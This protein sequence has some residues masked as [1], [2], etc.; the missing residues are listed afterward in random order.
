MIRSFEIQNYRGFDHLLLGDLSRVN[1]ITGRNNTGK[2]SILEALFLHAGYHNPGLATR[3]NAFRGLE[4]ARPE[5]TEVWGWLFHSKNVAQAIRLTSLD[6]DASTRELVV[7]LAGANE[8]SDSDAAT[9]DAQTG[10]R[11]VELMLAYS[12]STGESSHASARLT[13]GGIRLQLGRP[14]PAGGG[15]FVS[16]GLFA[17]GEDA[18]RLS[19]LQEV[20]REDEVRDA[21]RIV[22]PRLRRI[23]VSVVGGTA[24]V[25]GD[26][27]MGRLLPV[28][29]MGEGCARLLSI[30]L[31]V[32]AMPGGIVLIDEIENGFHHSILQDVWQAIGNAAERVNA[33]VFATTHSYECIRGAHRAFS[34]WLNYEFR[35]HR[36]DMTRAGVK[37]VTYDRETIES[38]LNAEMEV[39]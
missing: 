5:P 30:L 17:H 13:E 4:S 11:P 7:S 15:V 31:A 1:L 39:R 34:S 18:E 38:A 24:L 9:S 28:A 16:A 26:I 23:V 27:G 22:E 19:R 20:H 8:V 2:T 33:Q 10:T 21:L 32:T 29:F 35:L 12:T 6:D 3:V 14:S 25:Q 37:A 36:L